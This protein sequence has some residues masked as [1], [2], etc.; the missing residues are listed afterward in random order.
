[1]NSS[2]VTSV[3]KYMR[4]NEVS[5]PIIKKKKKYGG[6]SVKQM[7]TTLC[8]INRRSSQQV[9]HKIDVLE[10]SQENTCVGFSFNEI[11]G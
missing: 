9:F 10:N 5:Q 6:K 2:E 3:E 7:K 4:V 11:V 8:S 1:M